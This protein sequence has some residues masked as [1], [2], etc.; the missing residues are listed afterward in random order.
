MCLARKELSGQDEGRD[1]SSLVYGAFHLDEHSHQ[2]GKIATPCE[3]SSTPVLAR[4]VGVQG[5]EG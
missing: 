4:N 2:L 5:S 3:S 1:P